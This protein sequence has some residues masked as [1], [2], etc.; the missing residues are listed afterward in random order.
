MPGLWK[1]LRIWEI[2]GR[3]IR[4]LRFYPGWADKGLIQTKKIGR[5]NEYTAIVSEEDYQTAQTQTLLNK[6]YEGSAK[7]LVSTLIQREMLSAGD[8][9][10]LKKFWE[11]GENKG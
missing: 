8:Y 6:L 2:H 1:C 7:G 4:S 3:K 10:E 5:R 11:S 9:E